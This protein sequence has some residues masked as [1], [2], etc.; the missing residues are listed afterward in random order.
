[1]SNKPNK[2]D[3]RFGSFWT[4]PNCEG[5]PEFDHAGMMQHMRSV[6]SIDTKN[7]KGKRSMVMQMDGSDFY[8][9]VYEWEVGGLKFNQSTCNKRTG[10]NAAMWGGDEE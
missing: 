8:S 3:R 7:T 1:M 10:M 4:C 5:T 6:H 9:S 2:E